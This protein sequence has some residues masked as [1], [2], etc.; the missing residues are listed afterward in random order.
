MNNLC[1]VLGNNFLLSRLV[2]ESNSSSYNSSF[3]WTHQ[4]KKDEKEFPIT[5]ELSD[6]VII[7]EIQLHCL[8]N[9]RISNASS[10]FPSFIRIET[11]TSLSRLIPCG[12]YPC[13]ITPSSSNSTNCY[14]YCFKFKIRP[15]VIRYLRLNIYCPEKSNYIAISRIQFRGYTLENFTI[16]EMESNGQQISI[17]QSLELLSHCLKFSNVQQYLA[18]LDLMN[19]IFSLLQKLSIETHTLIEKIILSLSQYNIE[20]SSLIL[21][22]LLLEG[23]TSYHAA[24]AGKICGLKDSKTNERL[25]NLRDFVFDQLNKQFSISMLS[26]YLMPF[27]NALSYAINQH[28]PNIFI[29]VSEE[30]MKLLLK[31]ASNSADDSLMEEGALKLLSSLV[32]SNSLNFQILIPE[33]ISSLDCKTI[34]I[35]GILAISSPICSSELLKSNIFPFLISQMKDEKMIST[36]N[37]EDILSFLE[38]VAHDQN[39]KSWIG[40]N[41]FDQLFD[42]CNQSDYYKSNILSNSLN[43]L[44]SCSNLHSSNQEKIASYLLEKMKE[45]PSDSIILQTNK[46]SIQTSISD[47]MLQW[48]IDIFSF[49]DKVALCLYSLQNEEYIWNN[50]TE[51]SKLEPIKVDL[52][53]CNSS[54]DVDDNLKT[55]TASDRSKYVWRTALGTRCMKSGVHKWEVVIEK[56]TS[57]CNIMIGVCEQHQ[58]L[59][60][61]PGGA[62]HNAAGW[63]YY[64]CAPG[65]VYHNSRNKDYGE[66]FRIGDVIG[67]VLDMDEGTLSFSKNGSDFGIAFSTE[68]LGK[69]LYP[70]ISLY[71]I[72]DRVS[73][74]DDMSEISNK[75]INGLSKYKMDL[76]SPLRFLRPLPMLMCSLNTTL[77][78]IEKAILG[79]EESK[80]I[81]F[82]VQNI[83]KGESFEILDNISTSL[84]HLTKQLLDNGFNSEIIDIKYEIIEDNNNFSARNIINPALKIKPIFQLFA[85]QE[86][87]SKLVTLLYNRLINNLNNKSEDI[88]WQ[89]WLIELSAYLKVY[90]YANLFINNSDC[91]IILF[92]L[93]KGL[94]DSEQEE[95]PLPSSLL[96]N[97]FQPLR[98]ILFQ[99]FSLYNDEKTNFII[100]KGVLESF[101]MEF[102][103]CHL[104]E[105]CSVEH[106]K[107]NLFHTKTIQQY[108]KDSINDA[109]KTKFSSKVLISSNNNSNAPK[110]YW[111]KGTGYGTNSDGNSNWNHVE[112]M[113]LQDLKA[114]QINEIFEGLLNYLNGPLPEGLYSLLE[115][116]CLIPILEGYLRNDSLLDMGRHIFLYINVLKIVRLLVSHENLIS[117]ID[118]LSNQASSIYDLMNNLNSIAEI[119]LKKVNSVKILEEKSKEKN[120]QVVEINEVELLIEENKKNNEKSKETSTEDQILLA[121]EINKTSNLVKKQIDRYRKL[122]RLTQ[123]ENVDIN[124]NKNQ[125]SSLEI[126]YKNS[127]KPLQFGE[128]SM[129]DENGEY[130]HYYKQRIRGEEM[131]ASSSKVKRLIQEVG[132]L[133]N[134]LPLYLDSSV[135]LRVDEDRIDIM[136]ALIT[137]PEGTPYESGCFQVNI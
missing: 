16:R 80:F 30:E 88:K 58:Q 14:T 91:Y 100:R 18:Q 70:A 127:L 89:R 123:K 71:D 3:V 119:I 83:Y 61:Y 85:E 42:L 52:N 2:E 66:P 103:L 130:N 121:T 43:V 24:L 10:M 9:Y 6:D 17:I 56:T 97:P 74:K 94:K 33:S 120:H 131:I 87:L 63:S 62:D 108:L 90:G 77:Y 104:S 118:T 93:M 19:Q 32:Q 129:L 67:V 22:K 48:M 109:K 96:E 113:K 82:Y 34:Q 114:K 95:F 106:R 45:I 55:V 128:T 86:G 64:G 46:I 8:Q 44:L 135:F 84:F 4:F 51:T 1:E 23:Q 78:D 37:L 68:L 115:A 132:S 7:K 12:R 76:S 11:G 25:Q 15:D 137:G 21:K 116:S 105:L 125:Q 39:I 92:R 49:E 47:I 59:T 75:N 35:L 102:L 41:L 126:I 72:G 26:S 117:L 79:I 5:I 65:Y 122:I 69:E 136:R 60:A 20:L 111:A 110:S 112:Y 81:K 99:L 40:K 107:S 53:F 50:A 57:T 98:I 28:F 31:F 27:L 54:L 124:E 38:K 36:I 133:S 13:I 29:S 73:F 101:S 134:G